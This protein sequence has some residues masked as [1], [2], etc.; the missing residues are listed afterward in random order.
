M[1]DTLNP[2]QRAAVTHPPAPIL[3]QAGAGTGKT[4]VLTYRIAYL[5]EH[6]RVRPSNILAVTFT[7]KAAAELRER[8][9]DLLGTRAR[10][11]ATGTFHA[12]CCRVLRAEI[13]GRI[14]AY[15][16]DFTI[17]ATDEQLQLAAEALEK[18]TERPPMQFEPD[19]L[20]WHISRAKSRMLTPTAMA[21]S[22]RRS[23]DKVDGFVAACYQRYQR[24]LERAN[25]LDFDDL[26]FLT[27]QLFSG[28][29]EVLEK[30]QEQWNH[31]LVDEYQDTDPSQYTLLEMLTRPV[32]PDQ[33]RSLF[34]VGDGMQAIYGFRNADYTIITRFANDFPEAV[35]YDLTTNYRSRQV[36][37]DAAY[38]VIRHSR[39][40]KPM[41]LRS[42]SSVAGE[43]QSLFLVEADHAKDEATHVARAIE[44]VARIGRRYGEMA[45]L[46]RTRHMSRA[47]ET[48]LRH[49]GIPYHV[50]GSTGFYDRAVI[51]DALAY[52]RAVVNPADSLSLTRIVNRPAR[53]IGA[54]SLAK[55]TDFAAQQGISLSEALGHPIAQS[56]LS[57]KA[58]DGTRLFSSLLKRWRHLADQGYPPDHLLH[59]VLEQSGYFAFLEERMEPEE[60]ADAKA[61]LEELE[62]AAEEHDDLK[63]FLQ[64]VALLS[65][66][67][68]EKEETTRVELLT[69]HAAKG[70]EWPIVFLVGL[71]EGTLPHKRSLATVAGIEEERRLCYVAMTRAKERLYLFCAKSRTR[72]QQDKPSRFLTEVQDYGKERKGRGG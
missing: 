43:G 5:I 56:Q 4:R 70:L 15:T 69:I 19:T 42:A 58:A 9:R 29:L 6:Y 46:Y 36:I 54:Q 25:A 67:D 72:G 1:F 37:L 71:E 64:E 39:A 28:H 16:S 49:Q 32:Y 22:A 26:I 47:L 3:V 10:G 60:L 11:I 63:S 14:G 2:Q 8:L 34:A 40:V 66:M 21:R 35:V 44:E 27:Y 61:H 17:Y 38:A 68:T 31:V 20:L 52:L 13:T 53:G 23:G 55:M 57:A 18:T 33:A 45:I 59:D 50:R 12:I 65:N 24:L 48:A 51:R 30:Y 62:T 7:N 41:E